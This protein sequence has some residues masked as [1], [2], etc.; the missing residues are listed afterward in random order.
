MALSANAKD[1]LNLDPSSKN[2]SPKSNPGRNTTKQQVRHRASVACASCRDRRIRCV[3]PKNQTECTACAKSG[4]ECIIKNDDERRR[5]ISKAYMSSLSDRISMLEGLLLEK[6]VVP[7]PATH[8]PKTR[9]DVQDTI[10]TTAGNTDPSP[11]SDS[12]SPGSEDHSPPDYQNDDFT[13]RESELATTNSREKQQAY[14]RSN[15]DS[16]FR[17][18][19]PK[20]EDIIH[21]LLSTKGNLSFDQISGRLRFFGPTANSHVYAESTSLSYAREPPEQIRRAEKIIQSL[22]SETHDYLVDGFF[23]YYNS[24]IQIID[25]NA[26]E[27]DRMSKSSK[28]YS[29]FL[30]ITVLAMGYRVADME[31]DDMRKITLSPRESS[32]HREAKHMLDI[33]LE[34]PGGISSVQALLLLGDLECGVGRD[35]TG[36]MYSGMAN[37]LAFDIGLHLDCTSSMSEQ[38]TKIRNMVMQ[39]CVIYDRYWGLFLGRPLAI[40][41]QDVDLLSNRFS[42]LASFGLDAPKMDL[43]SEI[44]EQLIE[45]MELAGRIVEIRDLSNSSQ[46]AEQTGAFATNEAEENR[47][48][49]VINLDRQLQNWYRRLPDRMAWKPSNVKTAPYSFFLLHQQYHVTMILLH[50]PWAKYGSISGDSSSTGSHPSPESDRKANSESPGHH[51]T[52]EGSSMSTDD[53]QRVVHGSRTSLARSI[54]TQQAIRVARIFWQHRQRFDGRKIF[55]TGMQH[56]GT[57]SIAD[58]SATYHPASRMDDLLKA[59][60]DQ[61]RSSMTD[62][63]RSRS[64]SAGQQ[65]ISIGA[66]SARSGVSYDGN[67]SV[68]VVPVRREADT[69]FNQPLKKRRPSVHRQT[70]DYASSK[71]SYLGITSQP[72]PPLSLP[73]GQQSQSPLDPTMFPMNLHSQPEQLGLTLVGTNAVNMHHPDLATGHMVGTLNAAN[74]G[75]PLHDNWGLPNMQPSFPQGQFHGAIDWSAGTAGLSASSVLNQSA[76]MST[77][78]MSGIAAFS[79][80][81]EPPKFGGSEGGMHES[82]SSKLPHIG[83]NWTSTNV[84]PVGSGRMQEYGPNLGKTTRLND[85]NNDEQRNYSLDFF[86]FG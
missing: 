49:Q 42:Q 76:A 31:R 40:K 61:I 69:D 43:T 45:L 72:A 71:P 24:V 86:N 18:L 64:G 75:N 39:A 5:P 20:Q 80:A 73:Y 23:H 30:H 83:T 60:L 50:R 14:A 82:S 78:I 16:P 48:L 85:V 68:P 15:E 70:S 22:S 17:I 51:F 32:L 55:I 38:D 65:A 2:A 41:S 37:R 59:V 26:F 44:Y 6:G 29:H 19:D 10:A 81:K 7:P 33:E 13:T 62:V 4:A 34:R 53:R 74:L 36:W 25:R 84:G 12:K 27:A 28:F 67:T 8:P 21:R 66:S 77:G 79:S 3:V 58:M 54:C 52:A 63:S 56:A 9:H 35:N 11:Q 47:Y 57:A 1:A 46:V